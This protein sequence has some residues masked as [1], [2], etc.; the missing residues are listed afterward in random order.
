MCWTDSWSAQVHADALGL[1]D[2]HDFVNAPMDLETVSR[3]VDAQKYEKKEE[4]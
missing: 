3:N 1:H 2:Y 4:F